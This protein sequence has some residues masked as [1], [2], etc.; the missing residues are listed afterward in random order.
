MK[1]YF[2]ALSKKHFEY[3]ERYNIKV[4][5]LR[6][7]FESRKNH[8]FF[9]HPCIKHFF[10][11]SGAFSAANQGE[12]INIKRYAEYIFKYTDKITV[13]AN[14]DV[15]GDPEQT[16]KNQK[17]LEKLGLNPLPVYHYG[18]KLELLQY[19]CNNYKYIALGGLAGENLSYNKLDP[20]LT[21]IF[22]MFPNNKFHGFGM[23]NILLIKAFPWESVDS[24]TYLGGSKYGLIIHEEVTVHYKKLTN[25][26]DWKILT[27]FLDRTK[28]TIDDFFNDYILRDI[29]NIEQN[30]KFIDSPKCYEKINQLSLF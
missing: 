26:K 19:Y 27:E 23:N 28:M 29:F 17:I 12:E 16:L 10:L 24:T 7:Y 22:N 21:K 3:L 18:E 14:L 5:Y 13:Y 6:S 2:S 11:D 25:I 1:I 9:E 4:D 15:K 8:K 30:L 20:W